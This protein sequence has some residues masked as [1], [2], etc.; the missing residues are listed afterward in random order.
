MR[1]DIASNA[2]R[3]EGDAIVGD[4][5]TRATRHGLNVPLYRAAYC[6]LQV[7]AHQHTPGAAAQQ[8]FK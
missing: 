5:I 4:M 6:H 2:P 3:L 8:P 1:R 7:Y